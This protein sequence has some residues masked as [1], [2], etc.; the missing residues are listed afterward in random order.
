MDSVDRLKSLVSNKDHNSISRGEVWLG[1][2]FIKSAGLD[3]TIDNHFRVAK[4]LG[5]DMVCLSVSE[6]PHHNEN[7]GYRYFQPKDIRSDFRDRTRL[8][9]VVVDGPFQ[10]MVNTRGL[11]EVLLSWVNDRESAIFTYA[12]EQKIALDLVEQMLEREVD[13]I[14]LADDFAGDQAPFMNPIELDK[15][16][17]PF[18]TQAVSLIRKAGAS[19]FLHCC[20]N[21]QQLLP[22][23]KAWNLDGL[24]AIQ[25]SN[26]DL[27][28]LDTE[29]GGLLM[30]GIDATLLETDTPSHDEIE[31]LKRF[32]THFAK[33]E[34]LIL[35]SSCGLYKSDYWGRIQRIYENL[36]M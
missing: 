33:H 2:A 23:I 19:V 29:L 12:A 21:L 30:A 15:I 8:L 18:Y 35:C 9:A 7:L 11:M 14:I 31:A 22:L 13:T 25:I 17:T 36:H 26:N 5:L 6:N 4:Q 20:G 16:C 34:R 32:V 10:R 28:L 27:G 24:A 3:D 1:S